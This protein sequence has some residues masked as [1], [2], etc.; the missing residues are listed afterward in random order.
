MKHLQR[1]AA[2]GAAAVLACAAVAA[3]ASAGHGR[4]GGGHH[5]ERGYHHGGGGCGG[6]HACTSIVSADVAGSAL[7]LT[8]AQLSAQLKAGQTLA[9]V[10]AAAN[11]PVDTL[12]TAITNAAKTG[13]DAAVAAGTLTAGQAQ[14]VLV[15]VPQQ[16]AALVSGSARS[17][18]ALVGSRCGLISLDISAA[19]SLLGLTPVQLQVEL[20]AGKTLAAI[21]AAVGKTVE[22]VTQAATAAAKT[23]VDAGVAA[24]SLTQSQGQTLTSGVSQTITTVIG[25]ALGK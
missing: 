25:G 10:A 20:N 3:P 17:A 12:A 18:K 21:A 14:A 15:G 11:K 9:Q 13:L 6:G 7:G 4:G 5:A 8:R 2:V 22:G 23:T 1:M 19:A 16:V 24:G